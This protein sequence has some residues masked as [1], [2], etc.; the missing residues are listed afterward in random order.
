MGADVR[1][2]DESKGNN[3]VVGCLRILK[4]LNNRVLVGSGL[5]RLCKGSYKSQKRIEEF[6]VLTPQN[7]LEFHLPYLEPETHNVLLETTLF[8]RGQC[9]LDSIIC[10]IGF[11][12]WF[13][14]M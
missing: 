6:F 4:S 9:T 12:I 7:Q 5:T 11:N 14:G 13:G 3:N 1:R 2:R 8:H 10:Q